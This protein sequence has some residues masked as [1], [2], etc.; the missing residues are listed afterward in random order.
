[1]SKFAILLGGDVTPTPRLASQM[2][3]A[4]V[5]AADSGMRHAASLGVK[6]ELWLGDFD[7]ANQI[8]LNEHAT[9]ERQTFPAAKDATDGALAVREAI[10]RGATEIVL[11]GAFGGQMDHALAHSTKLIA[12]AEQNIKCCASSGTEEAWPLVTQL[13]LWQIARGTRISIVGLTPL[14]SL[15]ITGVRWP[16]RNHDVPMGSTLT[17]S[18]EVA[19][20][21][22]VSVQSG[23][24]LVMLYPGMKR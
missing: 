24:A 15:T 16:L 11:A 6:P 20:D 3:G 12:L 18:N 23:R 7:S 22:A 1:M 13:S 17:L 21:V 8:L 19:G 4:R 14:T 9:V 2:S 10:A 5:I